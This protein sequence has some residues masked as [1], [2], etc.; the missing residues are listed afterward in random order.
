MTQQNENTRQG[1]DG[2]HVYVTPQNLRK[3]KQGLP[4]VTP[5]RARPVHRRMI[6]YDTKPGEVYT[7]ATRMIIRIIR[8]GMRIDMRRFLDNP[9]LDDPRAWLLDKTIILAPEKPRP[10]RVSD[11]T[12]FDEWFELDGHW[13][14]VKDTAPIESISGFGF[15]H[16]LVPT[17]LNSPGF[18]KCGYLCTDRKEGYIRLEAALSWVTRRHTPAIIRSLDA[19]AA[20]GFADVQELVN[21]LGELREQDTPRGNYPRV[22]VR[23]RVRCN[24]IGVWRGDDIPPDASPEETRLRYY[25]KKAGVSTISELESLDPTDFEQPLRGFIRRA[26]NRGTGHKWKWIRVR[27]FNADALVRHLFEMADAERP[28]LFLKIEP[29][30]RG[31]DCPTAMYHIL[32]RNGQLYINKIQE[33]PVW[34]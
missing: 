14:C 32:N 19:L 22:Y 17:W 3:F 23:R 34:A 7:V 11:D 28:H 4:K 25:L 6:S 27:V 29:R 18:P 24:P 30:G 31:I 20:F 21:V 2:Q 1:D 15:F 9:L 13:L 26:I 10:Y 5:P 16:L 12:M 33:L 8:P